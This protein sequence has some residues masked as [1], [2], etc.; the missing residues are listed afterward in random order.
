MSETTDVLVRKLYVFVYS[1]YPKD[2]INP[3]RGTSGVVHDGIVCDGCEKQIQGFRYKCLQCIDYDLCANCDARGIHEDHCMLRLVVPAQWKPHWGRRIAGLMNRSMR[4]ASNAADEDKELKCP[5]SRVNSCKED[6]HDKHFNREKE[7]CRNKDNHHG[8]A[9][10]DKDKQHYG[11]Q[12]KRRCNDNNG[13]SWTNTLA[14]YL[15]DWA[16][17][18]S[19]CPSMEKVNQD[20]AKQAATA[21]SA[22]SSANA[23]AA[24]FT[25][26]TKTKGP[27]VFMTGTLPKKHT[28]EEPSVKIPKTELTDEKQKSDDTNTKDDKQKSEKK[29]PMDSYM[30]LLKMVGEN[31]TPFIETFVNPQPVSGGMCDIQKAAADA[32]AAAVASHF[33]AQPNPYG[34]KQD[35]TESTKKNDPMTTEAT[36]NKT[37]MDTDKNNN[38]NV[39]TTGADKSSDNE[40]WTI[41]GANV[42]PST[43]DVDS[44]KVIKSII[45]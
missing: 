19:E 15:N 23:A 20:I 38:A 22:A 26:T 8:G 5:F 30:E 37:P 33:N 25:G 6:R 10:K 21:A 29:N 2:S 41:I 43:V 18:P 11:K 31:F 44:S 1:E 3:S 4:K 16:N 7:H 28:T 35:N 12:H 13:V 40:D 34:F 24:D 27:L 9:G 36:E 32:A 45:Y 17:V 42:N 14:S 39:E